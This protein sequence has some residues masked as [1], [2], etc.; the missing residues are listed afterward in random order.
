MANS[1]P[2]L[3]HAPKGSLC[4]IT[5]SFASSRRSAKRCNSDVCRLRR[6]ASA[7]DLP[8]AVVTPVNHPSSSHACAT[9]KQLHTRIST[10]GSA[11]ICDPTY[12]TVSSRDHVVYHTA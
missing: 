5:Q 1:T 12:C 8:S 3:S 7:P 9:S 2:L 4:P 6:T 10:Q 11:H